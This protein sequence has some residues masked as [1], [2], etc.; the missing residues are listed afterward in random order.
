M[1]AFVAI[2]TIIAHPENNANMLQGRMGTYAVVHPYNGNATQACN[3]AANIAT[4][5]HS[6]ESQ[7][8]CAK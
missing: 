6:E 8:P 7:R 3:I 4:C 2:F 5:N 1:Q